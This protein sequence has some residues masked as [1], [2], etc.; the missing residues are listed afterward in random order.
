MKIK[1]SPEGSKNFEKPKIE[2]GLYEAK[3]IEVKDISEGQYGPR[4]AFIF[5]VLT[6]KES[7]E[8]SHVAYVPEV[9]NPDNKFGKVLLALG[10]DLGK[11]IDTES[12]KDKVV[13]VMVEDYEY[14]EE[15]T[16]KVASTISKVKPLAS[17][18]KQE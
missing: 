8:L 9:A 17:V 6:V 2:E 14:D 5:S 1:T 3:L 13:K 4:V 15:N 10:C 12:L 7:V 16:K 11:E 18:E